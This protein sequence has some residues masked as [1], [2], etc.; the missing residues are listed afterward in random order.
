MTR[1]AGVVVE[2]NLTAGLVTESTGL[3]FPEN[4][5]TATDNCVFDPIGAVRRRDGIDK[6]IGSAAFLTV[7]EEN[8]CVEHVWENVAGNGSLTFLVQQIG[9][10][11]MFFNSDG[12][13]TLSD[14]F[15]GIVFI[16][17]Y[18]IDAGNVYNNHCGFANGLGKLI[19]THPF[20][21]PFFVS[22]D[23]DT[24]TL[25]SERI[26][27]RTRDFKGVDPRPVERGL[28]LTVEHR[29][30]LFNQGWR[31]Y[32]LG[33]YRD[34]IGVWPSDFEVWWLYKGINPNNQAEEFLPIPTALQVIRNEIDRG[35][36]LAPNGSMILNEFYQDRAAAMSY[37]GLP[38]QTSGTNRP[39]TCAFHAGRVFY[40]GVNYKEW[41]ARI[42]FSQ[43]VQR[44]VQLGACHQENDP[45]SQ[46]APDLLATD[47]GVISIPEA[48]SILKLWSINNSLLAVCTNGVWEITGSSG[49]GF[50]AIDYTV[51]KISSLTTN[52]NL[53][54]VNVNGS[55]FWWGQDGIYAAVSE[56]AGAGIAIQNI[57]EKT[58]KT[59]FYDI[60]EGNRR[61][62][63]G[64]FNPREQVIQWLYRTGEALTIKERFTYNRIL[65]FSLKNTAFYDWGVSSTVMRLKGIFALK[66]SGEVTVQDPV[67]DNAGAVVT[68]NSLN[69]VTV[70]KDITTTNSA[71]FKYTVMNTNTLDWTFGE[72]R[73]GTRSDW[74]TSQVV[75]SV[76]E[77]SF[78]TG[79]KLR[80]QG[81]TKFQENYIR[82]YNEGNG[83][84]QF[85]SQWDYKGNPNS[86]R[87]GSP[88]LVT[89]FDSI[90]GD[91]VQTRRKK[92]RGHGLALQITV[93]SVDDEDFNIIGWSGFDTSNA[94][95]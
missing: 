53:S 71:E 77:S 92:V 51:K 23:R 74:T 26:N 1:N 47:G 20:C 63:K 75:P 9:N 13:Q 2:N 38:V 69:V 48:G 82:F 46:Y 6:E 8:V 33:K 50:S 81:M 91:S 59:F 64:V 44:D 30:N 17:G 68:D 7:S 88:Q 5:V 25:S 76:F 58:I 55:P 89:F 85:Y 70:P 10:L 35:N 56:A 79:F 12:S 86:R 27:I 34:Q 84:F 66:G 95:P 52:T 45:T 83:S 18:A 39:S 15:V 28:D 40:S 21:D 31:E 29:Y 43:I 14:S 19:V 60:L 72:A 32:Q 41:S 62:V 78:T 42:Y 80:G 94:R 49:I 24:A 4:A 61:F 67:T 11:L 73:A 65:N 87:F 36:S 57:S 37:F 54:F 90:E 16:P 93:K 22:Y 3:N